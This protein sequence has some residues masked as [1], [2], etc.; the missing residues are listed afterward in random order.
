MIMDSSF[1]FILVSRQYMMLWVELSSERASYPRP[2][3]DLE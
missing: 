1:D 2:S 3:W